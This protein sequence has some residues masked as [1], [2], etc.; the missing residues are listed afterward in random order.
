MAGRLPGCSDASAADCPAPVSLPL[1]AETSADGITISYLSRYF[2]A[3]AD[4]TEEAILN[5]VCM[6]TTMVGVNGRTSHALP[7]E[8]VREVLS[9][10]KR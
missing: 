2:E 6:A 8:L 9:A 10:Y 5:A 7:L 4:A 1:D 3:A